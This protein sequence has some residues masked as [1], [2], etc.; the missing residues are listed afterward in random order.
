[1]TL[2][3]LLTPPPAGRTCQ[4]GGSRWLLGC[5]AVRRC[6]R[7]RCALPRSAPSVAQRTLVGC[8][9]SFVRA[10][11]EPQSPHPAPRMPGLACAVS[12]SCQSLSRATP[13]YFLLIEDAPEGTA[14]RSSEGAERA[15]HLRQ[16]MEECLKLPRVVLDRFT[17]A[18]LILDSIADCGGSSPASSSHLLTSTQASHPAPYH[19]FTLCLSAGSPS[20]ILTLT[21]S[22]HAQPRFTEPTFL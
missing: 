20:S 10:T 5:A 1:M 9:C 11:R 14:E 17:R 2:C 19:W 18:S 7:S 6:A 4:C 12:R 22:R 8:S 16:Q 13:F 21:V 15:L 3:R